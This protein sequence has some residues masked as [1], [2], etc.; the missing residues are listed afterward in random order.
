MP[1]SS[2]NRPLHRR[3][4]K[5]R[6]RDLG[7]EISKRAKALMKDKP[8]EPTQSTRFIGRTGVKKSP[9]ALAT[10]EKVIA[11]KNSD[12]ANLILTRKGRDTRESR[13]SGK[14]RTI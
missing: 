7:G 14:C 2:R 1:M 10:A 6:V 4:K 12:Q 9:T 8:S 3:G 5:S 11:N 13:L